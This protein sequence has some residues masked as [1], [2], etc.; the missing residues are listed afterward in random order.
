MKILVAHN[1]YQGLGGEDSVVAAEPALL[2]THGH[3]VVSYR[4]SNYDL[5]GR[6]GI[7]AL[8]V[9]AETVWSFSSHGALQEILKTERPDVAHFH[10]TFPLISPSAY[11]A[12][13]EA[14]VP[15]EK[16]FNNYRLVWPAATI[17]LERKV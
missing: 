4:R 16:K 8:A 6:N 2:R 14:V 5:K 11:Y 15:V 9:A 13:A 17:M 10:N 12:C 1:E 7:D 3:D